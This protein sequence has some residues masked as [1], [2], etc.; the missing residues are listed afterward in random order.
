[1]PGRL[2]S[3]CLVCPWC[4]AERECRLSG[5]RIDAGAIAACPVGANVACLRCGSREHLVID[6]P[7]PTGMTP[8]MARRELRSG[9]CCGAPREATD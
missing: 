5:I 2:I 9:G 7:I 4:V 6:C 8:A 3:I 1:M